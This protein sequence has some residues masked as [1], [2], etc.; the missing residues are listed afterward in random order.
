MVTEFSVEIASVNF[1]Q[2]VQ[3]QESMEK[4]S[5]IHNLSLVPVSI[6]TNQGKKSCSSYSGLAYKLCLQALC[7]L[8]INSFTAKDK[9]D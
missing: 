2:I 1:D 4:D 6:T 5:R 7:E 8:P 3:V 9:F